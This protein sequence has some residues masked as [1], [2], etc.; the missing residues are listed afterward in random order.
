[1]IGEGSVE[2]GN[3]IECKRRVLLQRHRPNFVAL[4]RLR[5]RRAKRAD[6]PHREIQVSG[7]FLPVYAPQ[8]ARPYR[9]DSLTLSLEI[10]VTSLSN[11]CTAKRTVLTAGDDRIRPHD[12]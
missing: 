10:V 11:G 8:L 3:A 7:G 12:V 1:M 2:G 9:N 4:V 6:A 5:R